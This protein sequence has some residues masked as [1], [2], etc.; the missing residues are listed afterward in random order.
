MTS[1]PSVVKLRSMLPRGRRRQSSED[2]CQLCHALVV[3][4]RIQRQDATGQKRF[5]TFPH[6]NAIAFAI[7]LD[8]TECPRSLSTEGDISRSNVLGGVVCGDEFHPVALKH[9][10]ASSRPRT[11]PAFAHDLKRTLNLLRGETP[12]CDE[13]GTAQIAVRLRACP[14]QR[15]E[16]LLACPAV[17][18]CNSPPG[19]GICFLTSVRQRRG[20]SPPPSARPCCIMQH[21]DLAAL[22]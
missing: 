12:S 20:G 1:S 5:T 3:L 8:G 14:S 16:P 17:S 7:T 22:D 4:R 15:Q 18:G 11:N 13:A 10:L 19:P 6:G 21:A 9:L 2:R